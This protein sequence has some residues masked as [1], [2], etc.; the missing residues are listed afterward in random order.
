MILMNVISVFPDLASFQ[1]IG[2]QHS[3]LT[4]L[5]GNNRFDI[6]YI[7]MTVCWRNLDETCILFCKKFYQFEL[8]ICYVEVNN[9]EL[10]CVDTS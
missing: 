4:K 3:L 6:L 2:Y 10:N 1:H 5:V 9:Q 8:K 7:R